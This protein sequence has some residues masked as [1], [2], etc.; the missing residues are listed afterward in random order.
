MSGR[1]VIWIIVGMIVLGWISVLI[2]NPTPS[3][4]RRTIG[5]L[6]ILA[7]IGWLLWRHALASLADLPAWTLVSWMALLGIIRYALAGMLSRNE[8]W[9]NVLYSPQPS[10]FPD[11]PQI[12]TEGTDYFRG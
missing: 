10:N 1:W 9:G 4:W 11:G 7:G 3:T 8:T 12:R 5:L 2:N 6:M